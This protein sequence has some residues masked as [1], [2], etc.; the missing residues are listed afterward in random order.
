MKTRI[1]K[2]LS[3]GG[4]GSWLRWLPELALLALGCVGLLIA[5]EQPTSPDL[6]VH[7]WGTFTAVAGKDGKAATWSPLNGSTD[8]PQFVEHFSDTNYKRGL[9]GTIRM[10]TPV[11]YFYSPRDTTVSVK[12]SFSKGVMTEWY[13]HADQVEPSEMLR[14]NDLSRLQADG[15]IRWRSVGISPSLR[16]DFPFELK[17]NR[18]YAARETSSTPLHVKTHGGEQQEKFLFYRGV[19]AAS[20]PLSATQNADGGLSVRSLDENE[21]PAVILFER[22][23]ERVGYRLVRTP[24]RETVVEPPELTGDLDS[25]CGELE[26]ILVE[27]GLNADEARAMVATWRDSWFEEGSRVIYIVPRGFI[28]KI[29][30]LTVNPAPEQVVRVFVG[31][32]EIVTPQ[33][34]K[35]VRTALASHDEATLNK[36]GRFLEPI[37]QTARE[38]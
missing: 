21:I 16:G 35:A 30:P 8:L 1:K 19:S 24:A 4:P 6:T 27:Q 22:R 29:L 37:L 20:L 9:I 26:A 17:S 14:D 2:V 15:S 7:E 10:E 32:L 28:D 12:V 25:L 11:L 5:D 36:Y 38:K 13:P 3:A 18:Y 34:I 33:T 23:G 31:R